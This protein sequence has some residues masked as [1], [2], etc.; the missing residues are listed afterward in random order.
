MVIIGIKDVQSC[1]PSDKLQGYI[2]KDNKE[3]MD[4][5]KNLEAPLMEASQ[6]A[7]AVLAS[8][9]VSQVHTSESLVLHDLFQSRS[10]LPQYSSGMLDADGS[11]SI[12]RKELQPYTVTKAP[13]I[14]ILLGMLKHRAGPPGLSAR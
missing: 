9:T 1:E 6:T 11:I 7:D 2:N 12:H 13:H 8:H 5:K 4:P 14:E 10:L 3:N